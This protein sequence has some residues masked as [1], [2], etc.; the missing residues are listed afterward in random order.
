M[1]AW[2]PLGSEMSVGEMGSSTLTCKRRLNECQFDSLARGGRQR[3][4]HVRRQLLLVILHEDHL[5]ASGREELLEAFSSR[6]GERV[7]VV[8]DAPLSAQKGPERD[9]GGDREE[10]DQV[11]R[12][13]PVLYKL[14]SGNEKCSLERRK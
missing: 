3:T 14:A 10:R 7:A 12:S 11:N 8:V 6:D 1:N 9:G 5:L 13:R 4:N 2:T